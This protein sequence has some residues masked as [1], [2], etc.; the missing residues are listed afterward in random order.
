MTLK[1]IIKAGEGAAHSIQA[2]LLEKGKVYL[3]AHFIG[4]AMRVYDIV[5][6]WDEDVMRTTYE[7]APRVHRPCSGNAH[8]GILPAVSVTAS[9]RVSGARCRNRHVHSR[10]SVGPL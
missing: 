10:A 6:L 5:Q 1:N 7:V 4:V 8:L 3:T 9:R 2:H